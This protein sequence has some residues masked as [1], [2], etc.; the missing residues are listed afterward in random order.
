MGKLRSLN[1]CQFHNFLVALWI[2]RWIIIFFQG[3]KWFHDIFTP[4]LRGFNM[5]HGFNS[6][7]QCPIHEQSLS[8]PQY[9]MSVLLKDQEHLKKKKTPAHPPSSLRYYT[10]QFFLRP[11]F[12]RFDS[13][14]NNFFSI[15]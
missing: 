13:L 15:V 5:L 2:S 3:P 7:L 11:T 1:L 9:V 8:I 4:I 6:L 10:G 14:T 12:I